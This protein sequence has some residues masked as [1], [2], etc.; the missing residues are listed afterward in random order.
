MEPLT[1]KHMKRE[2][3]HHL[4]TWPKFF[5]K[6][7]N[8]VKRY[9]LRRDDR[10]FRVGDTLWLEEWNPKTKKYTG[11]YCVRTVLYI[12]RDFPGL[13]KGYCL[14]SIGAFNEVIHE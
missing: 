5:K 1:S 13:K 12:M 10:D 2:T 9:E 7:Y 8:N 6:V 4:K 3:V 11:D 14:M